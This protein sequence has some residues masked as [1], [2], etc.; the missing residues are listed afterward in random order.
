MSNLQSVPELSSYC[1]R[2]KGEQKGL[3]SGMEG[4]KKENVPDCS[5]LSSYKD[6]KKV[7][8]SGGNDSISKTNST[9]SQEIVYKTIRKNPGTQEQGGTNFSPPK[10]VDSRFKD[11]LF[12]ASVRTVLEH[13]SLESNMGNFRKYDSK[14]GGV[15]RD[16]LAFAE[17]ISSPRFTAE[18]AVNGGRGA[19]NFCVT[20][21]GRTRREAIEK[22]D[23]NCYRF[24]RWI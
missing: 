24:V 12:R 19:I 21:P 15:I 6:Y 10:P 11:P 20:L 5:P 16:W 4:Q 13:L 23:T 1:S 22:L 7:D 9:E 17:R 18:V 8:I 2:M 3:D 14:Y